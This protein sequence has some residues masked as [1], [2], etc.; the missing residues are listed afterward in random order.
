MTPTGKFQKLTIR[1]M[2][3]SDLSAVE[4]LD[5]ASFNDPW[6]DGSFAYELKPGQPNLCLVAVVGENEQLVGAIVVWLI[7]DEAHIGTIA[8]DPEYRHHG[9]GLMLLATALLQAAELGA[10]ASL[11]KVRAGNTAALKLYYGLG[12]EAVGLRAGYYKDNHED[13]LLLTNPRLDIEK[14]KKIA[15]QS[16][17]RFEDNLV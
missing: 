5:R 17:G 10:T 3:E 12:Y 8:V 4:A 2:V 6:P 16:Q 9:V 15:G 13:A 11:L 14:L 7:V 1:K